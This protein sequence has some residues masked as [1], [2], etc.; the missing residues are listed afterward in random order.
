MLLVNLSGDALGFQVLF[1]CVD[2]AVHLIL[3][4]V[5]L[6]LSDGVIL[7]SL[8]E[9]EFKLGGFTLTLDGHILFPVLDTFCK[10]FLHKAGIALQLVNLNAAH[11]LLLLGV[12]NHILVVKLGSIVGLTHAF[13]IKALL[14]SLE[15]DIFLGTVQLTEPLLE[16]CV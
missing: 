11:F 10:P 6:G 5:K 1:E 15:V 3:C 13:V 12:V 16:E 8:G 4:L 7:F 2:A 9:I 14:V